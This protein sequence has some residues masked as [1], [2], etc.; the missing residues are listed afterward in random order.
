MGPK[1]IDSK[2]ENDNG[3]KRKRQNAQLGLQSVEM[4]KV[5]AALEEKLKQ[6]GVYNLKTAKTEGIKKNLKPLNGYFSYHF[7]WFQNVSLIYQIHF[8]VLTMIK[9]KVRGT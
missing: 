6:N 9:Q 4:L 5:R 1:L 8:V 2:M 3:G 7:F